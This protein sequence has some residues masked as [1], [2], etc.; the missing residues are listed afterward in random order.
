MKTLF[1]FIAWAL[2]A[3]ILAA[4][5]LGLHTAYGKPLKIGWFYERVFIEYALDDPELLT[6]LGMLPPLMNWYGDDLTDRS[7]ERAR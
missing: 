6:S 2:L 3:V 7:P 5:A 4:T 1:K